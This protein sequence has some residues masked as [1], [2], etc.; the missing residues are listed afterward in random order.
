MID[1]YLLA[2]LDNRLSTL[3]LMETNFFEE[4]YLIDDLPKITYK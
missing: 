3:D 4:I 1:E 2:H